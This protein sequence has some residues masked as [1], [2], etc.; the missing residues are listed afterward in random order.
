MV[1]SNSWRRIACLAVFGMLLATGAMIGHALDGAYLGVELEDEADSTNGAYLFG[2]QDGSPAAS[3]GLK[4]GLRVIRCNDR[5]IANGKELV[6]FLTQASAGDRLV[7]IVR[8]KDGW[9]KKISVILGERKV[10]KPKKKRAYLGVEIGEAKAGIRV[11]AVRDGTPA[12]KAGLKQDDILTKANGKKLRSEEGFAE[13]LGDLAPGATLK[14][15]VL[16]GGWSNTLTVKLVEHPDERVPVPAGKVEERPKVAQPPRVRVRRIDRPAARKPG[17]MGFR[18]EPGDGG[19][20]IL[21]VT[22]DSPAERAGMKKGD[23]LLKIDGKR[24]G[25]SDSLY[26]VLQNYFEGDEISILIRRG[27]KEKELNIKF[28]RHP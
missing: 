8:N 18:G 23:I 10:E 20:K 24:T 19:V 11:V 1:S 17:W 15:D 9:E 3:A 26:S 5:E 27:E 4:K 21:S 7:L 28:G 13:L 25:D 12:A 14:L 16:R 2:I 6:Q 22:K